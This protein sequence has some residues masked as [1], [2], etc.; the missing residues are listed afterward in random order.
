MQWLTLTLTTTG[1]NIFLTKFIY[2]S[3]TDCRQHP[4][5]LVNFMLHDTS[6]SR[7]LKQSVVC[8]TLRAHFRTFCQLLI[9]PSVH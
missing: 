4:A 5:M 2:P 9:Q 7:D 6:K 8:F 3:G 1:S